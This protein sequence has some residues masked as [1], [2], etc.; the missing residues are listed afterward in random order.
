MESFPMH[1]PFV[2][3]NYLSRFRY[4]W[5]ATRLAFKLK[6]LLYGLFLA[7]LGLIG[8][9]IWQVVTAMNELSLNVLQYSLSDVVLGIVCAFGTS[10]HFFRKYPTYPMSRGSIEHVF[11]PDGVTSTST[12]AKREI[13]WREVKELLPLG[14]VMVLLMEPPQPRLLIDTEGLT[15]DQR[16]TVF[17]DFERSRSDNQRNQQ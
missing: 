12:D 4:T 15:A 1:E 11:H 5:L 10:I 9:G 7:G 3:T 14:R 16:A 6:P 2:I 8:Y 13:K 17:I